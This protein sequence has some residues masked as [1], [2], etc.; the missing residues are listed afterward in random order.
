MIKKSPTEMLLYEAVY[1]IRNLPGARLRQKLTSWPDTI[2]AGIKA[3]AALPHQPLYIR[4]SPQ[5][6]SN[7]DRMLDALMKVKETERR[8]LWARASNV[9]WKKLCAREGLSHVTLRKYYMSGLDKLTKLFK[10]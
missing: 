9:T 1:T 4:P 3:I 6:I 8:I 5:S 7:L 10:L 2:P